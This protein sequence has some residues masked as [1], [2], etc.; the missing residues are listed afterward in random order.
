MADPVVSRRGTRLALTGHSG[1]ELTLFDLDGRS[2]VRKQ[3]RSASQNVRLAAQCE[4]LRRAHAAGIACPAVFQ[5]GGE[6]GLFWFDM[7]YV[8]ADSLAHALAAG[9]EPDWAHLLPQVA[10]F[11]AL[12][13]QTS[14]GVI[15]AA[16]FPGK[17]GSIAAA[18]LANAAAASRSKT[19]CCAPT[20]G[21]C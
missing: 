4:K 7:E 17:L 14:T 16:Q 3:A 19:F 21:S 8:P 20:A 9:R 5:S 6:D 12:F 11:P 10:S 15:P 2:F 1:A 18:C 13:S